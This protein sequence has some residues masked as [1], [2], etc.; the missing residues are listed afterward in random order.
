MT[1]KINLRDSTH[2][3]RANSQLKITWDGANILSQ[4]Q[5]I[6]PVSKHAG[7]GNMGSYHARQVSI[8]PRILE[9]NKTT[10]IK[11]HLLH[12]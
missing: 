9:T 10:L 12:Q 7:E 2:G 11:P 3:R 6:Y 5:F 8:R 4:K 1:F